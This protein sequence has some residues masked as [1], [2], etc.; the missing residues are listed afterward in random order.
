MLLSELWG[1]PG[2][3]LERELT[4]VGSDPAGIDER[5][6][7]GR[8]EQAF[9][10]RLAGLPP[11]QRARSDLTHRASQL[12]TGHG[13]A[14]SEPEQVSATATRLHVSERSLREVFTSTVADPNSSR[15]SHACERYSRTRAR[16]PGRA[17]RPSS[18][19]TTSRT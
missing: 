13:T 2:A 17:W 18:A 3:Q 19:T 15:G 6:L 12:L 5:L 10:S 7:L 14:H 1:T 11:R 9:T 4:G 16:H 8:V